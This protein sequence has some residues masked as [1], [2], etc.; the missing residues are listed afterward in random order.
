MTTTKDEIVYGGL[1]QEHTYVRVDHVCA[2]VL[3]GGS[4]DGFSSYFLY[5]LPATTMCLFRE[6]GA[7]THDI[8]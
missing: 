1:D 2:L 8:D 7:N 5:S 3:S 4:M 6:S